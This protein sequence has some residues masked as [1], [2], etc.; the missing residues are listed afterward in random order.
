MA[1]RGHDKTAFECRAKSKALHLRYKKTVALNESSGHNR[2]TCPF[3]EELDRILCKKKDIYPEGGI[4]QTRQQGR[5]DS[6]TPTPSSED[7][8]QD[9]FTDGSQDTVDPQPSTRSHAGQENKWHTPEQVALWQ[10][11]HDSATEKT[12]FKALQ[13]TV[14]NGAL[15]DSGGMQTVAKLP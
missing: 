13:D 14:Y 15:Q 4:L 3:F 2:V 8:S 9:L 11:K 6:E 5:R 1:E 7:A 12:F 10:C